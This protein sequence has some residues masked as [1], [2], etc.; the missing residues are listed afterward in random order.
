[1]VPFAR[2]DLPAAIL[3]HN[4]IN[5]GEVFM[6]SNDLLSRKGVAVE[7]LFPAQ[8]AKIKSRQDAHERF[9][10]FS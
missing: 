1:M 6:P 8:F 4:K 9:S 2:V 10:R 3:P 5:F 7:K